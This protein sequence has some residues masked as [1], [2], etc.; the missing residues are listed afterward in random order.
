MGIGGFFYPP[1]VT[2]YAVEGK[3]SLALAVVLLSLL[4]LYGGLYINSSWSR[5]T[6]IG[7]GLLAKPLIPLVLSF[8]LLFGFWA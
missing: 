3:A 8:F 7:L 4:L 2:V 5:Y 6:V 1:A